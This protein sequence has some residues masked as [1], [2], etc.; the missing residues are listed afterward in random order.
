MRHTGVVRLTAA[1]GAAVIALDLLWGLAVGSTG[2]LAYG[3]L[4]LPAHLATC[5]IALVLVAS[6]VGSALSRP[7]VVAAL[8]ASVAIDIDHLP[9]YLGSQLLT[10]SLPRPYTHTLLVI[11]LLAMLGTIVRGAARAVSFGLALGVAA[12]LLR[13]LGTG[14]GVP[15]LWPIADASVTVPYAIYAAALSTAVAVTAWRGSGRGKRTRPRRAD[16]S[17]NAGLHGGS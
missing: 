3:L 13:D 11:A 10:G 7:F 9:H 17:P 15:L 12:H 14:P 8:I 1:L 6:L 4:D 2:N 5:L 16:P